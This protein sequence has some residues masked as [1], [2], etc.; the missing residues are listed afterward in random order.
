MRFIEWNTIRHF[1][2]LK[3]FGI[4]VEPYKQGIFCDNKT[5]AEP[6]VI[7]DLRKSTFQEPPYF[8]YRHEI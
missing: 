2:P 4:G 5:Q 6:D 8:R 1:A 3:R 7:I